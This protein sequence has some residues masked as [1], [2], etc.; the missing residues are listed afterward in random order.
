MIVYWVK[1]AAIYKRNILSGT[2]NSWANNR[3]RDGKG[4]HNILRNRKRLAKNERSGRVAEVIIATLEEAHAITRLTPWN[5]SSTHWSNFVTLVKDAS[6]IVMLPLHFSFIENSLLTDHQFITN[7]SPIYHSKCDAIQFV[8]NLFTTGSEWLGLKST[9][10]N[11]LV[12]NHSSIL[13][14]FS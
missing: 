2:T 7:L 1:Q 13:V 10:N 9:Q 6:D 8:H 4:Y 12:K 11:S 14:I 5:L 3:K